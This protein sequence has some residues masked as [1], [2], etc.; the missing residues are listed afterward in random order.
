MFKQ[1]KLTISCV[2]GFCVLLLTASAAIAQSTDIQGHWAEK[3]ITSWVQKGLASGYPDGTF[4]PDSN[5]TRA[6]FI[7]LTNQA[8]NFTATT[9]INYVD[10]ASSAW[11][12]PEIARAR[13]AGYISGYAEL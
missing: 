10:V 8:Y 6:E 12:A 2:L 9:D 3:Q 5:I 1:C 4:K 13:A 11:Y 7:T